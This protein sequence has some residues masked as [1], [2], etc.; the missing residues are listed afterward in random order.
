MN[1]PLIS[2][3]LIAP[4]IT[5]IPHLIFP[6]VI[7]WYEMGISHLSLRD[8][9]EKSQHRAWFIYRKMIHCR[10]CLTR[11]LLMLSPWQQVLSWSTEGM[12]NNQWWQRNVIWVSLCVESTV[13]ECDRSGMVWA[14][15]SIC[16]PGQS[17]FNL[18][19]LSSLTVHLRCTLH[20][21]WL[22]I[23]HFITSRTFPSRSQH[24]PFI[25]LGLQV[26]QTAKKKKNRLML[27]FC[28]TRLE[29]CICTHFPKKAHSRRH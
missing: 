23:P 22:K 6:T 11:Q 10:M 8:V 1:T 21:Q 12:K 28:K 27:G 16:N 7:C 3:H 4:K 29:M 19:L 14:V 2:C 20:R 26:W 15:G 5:P 9:V 13:V 24:S 25:A 17:I 18:W